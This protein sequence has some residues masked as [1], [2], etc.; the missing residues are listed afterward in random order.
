[1]T[2]KNQALLKLF[3]AIISTNP[4][5]DESA[6]DVWALELDGQRVQPDAPSVVMLTAK[7]GLTQHALNAL[8]KAGSD[9]LAVLQA[10]EDEG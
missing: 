7:F 2:K 4:S 8:S 9:A 10:D 3:G 5:N 6:N 1:M